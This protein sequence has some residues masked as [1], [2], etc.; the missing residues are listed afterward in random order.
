MARPRKPRREPAPGRRR[1]HG[2]ATVIAVRAHVEP[3]G[4]RVAAPPT[5]R[6]WPRFSLVVT[7]VARPR[8]G[9]PLWFGLWDLIDNDT[10]RVRSRGV[11]H[12]EDLSETEVEEL[13]RQCRRLRL[14]PP[15]T[16]AGF[17]EGVL[18][19]CA[20]KEELPLVGWFLPEDL[21]RLAV[22]WSGSR[23]TPGG[24]SLVLST[25]PA[26][27]TP[28]GSGRRRR[29]LLAN[30]E[31]EN[32]HRARIA[33]RMLDGQRPLISFL[34]RKD[35]DPVDLM[36]E[37]RGGRIDPRYRKPGRFVTLAKLASALA[38]KRLPT[39]AEACGRFG[40]R[41]PVVA[42]G[43]DIAAQLSGAV[44][45]QRSLVALYR[46]LLALHDT[47]AAG[48]IAP[49]QVHSPAS[50]GKAIMD[51]AGIRPP[52]TGSP[53]FPRWMLAVGMEALYGGETSVSWRAP[54]EPLPCLFVDYTSLYPVVAWLVGADRLL[55]A[56]R[57]DVVAE[58]AE[59]VGVWLESLRPDDLLRPDVHAELA[60]LFVELVPNG[61]L[62]PHRV[63]ADKHWK[64][65][66]GPLAASEPLW[67]PAADAL[68]SRFETGHV[69]RILRA[70]R[71]VPHGRQTG[72]KP[73]TLPS[74]RVVRPA[75]DLLF[76]LAEERLE[77][78][79]NGAKGCANACCS[80]VF[81]QMN[82]G[83]RRARTVQHVWRADGRH[84]A[85]QGTDVE[86][87]ARWYFPPLAAT[88]NAGGRLLLFLARHLVEQ[89]GCTV[90]Y[91]DTDSLATV[92][93]Q[94]GGLAPCDGG[95]E[96]DSDG[97][98]CVRALTFEQVLEA[99]APIETLNPYPPRPGRERPRLLKIEA[100]NLDAD[101]LVNAY[102]H[103][104]SAKNYDRYRLIHTDGG[105][106]V[107]ITKA[108]EHGLG[109]LHAYWQDGTGREWI[110]E[111]RAT[112]LR[113]ELGLPAEE[114]EF[115]ERLALSVIRITSW[116]ELKRLAPTLSPR[117]RGNGPR[118][119]SRIAV[120]HP[121]PLY[122]YDED[123]QRL[124]PVALWH[125]QATID[126]AQWRDL[127]TRRPLAIRAHGKRLG[128]A[129]L[130][131]GGPIA[132]KTIRDVF[133]HLARRHDHGLDHTGKPTSPATSGL[134]RVAPTRVALVVAIGRETSDLDRVGITTDPAYRLYLD[135][136][137]N[138]WTLARDVLHRHAR[139][140][141]DHGRPRNADKPWLTKRA[142]EIARRELAKTHPEIPVAIDPVVACALYLD[143]I[144]IGHVICGGCGQRLARR[145]L[146][147]C[148]SCRP[149]RKRLGR[150]R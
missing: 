109:H 112:L 103:A 61:D 117:R 100:D 33:I 89:A 36:P 130:T 77:G 18:Y 129:T 52:L 67:Y 119:F 142:G 21:G 37:G 94:M 58:N 86:V 6:P 25:W 14:P 40:V 45:R 139:H 72:L 121:D 66:V 31:I 70:V 65:Q 144:G 64:T 75:D 29:P 140:L 98:P 43:E 46:R 137:R 141:L 101:R 115:F 150:H 24:I 114:P 128:E 28:Q 113:A 84:H 48:R 54:A 47:V 93:G 62:L 91:V 4:W 3:A 78:V 96:H 116:E 111:G 133:E 97:R 82:D 68:R 59:Q 27:R 42:A 106:E 88:I 5:V 134:V 7:T 125:D 13:A 74:G 104:R 17:V 73:V 132:V 50:Y 102:L 12:A 57:L 122:A 90:A 69:P 34:R 85:E 56:D 81:A 99:V 92:A 63:P 126:T 149:R 20:Y 44:S 10:R 131:Q 145:E 108:S 148:A 19:R 135:P 124:T 39:L 32:P 15:V 71:V 2:E 123:G 127:R 26:P 138:G 53:E 143:L 38:G 107:E 22:D 30:G 8:E 87:P 79:W 1:A 120:L 55:K 23:D 60:L 83:E 136:K 147:W 49:D 105:V 16:R 41:S 80:G 118:P 51:A 35:P 146:R 95:T 11:F 76:A 9:E 110:A